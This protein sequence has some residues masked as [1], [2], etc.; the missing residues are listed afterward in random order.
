MTLP[1][2]EQQIGQLFIL[3]FRGGSVAADDPIVEDIRL[4]NLGGVILFDRHLASDKKIN[5]IESP[6]QLINLIDKLQE[7]AE[8]RLLIGIDQEGGMVSR[9]K[10]ES[11]FA[12]TPAAKELGNSKDLKATG[13]SARQTARMLGSLGINL[14]FAPVVDLNLNAKNP[15]IGKYDRSFSSDASKVIEHSKAWIKAHR[16]SNI[17]SCLKHFPGHGSSITDSHLGFVDISDSWSQTEL[18]P[19]RE[20][21]QSGLADTIMVGHLYNRTID[22][23]HPAT[24]SR[25]TLSTLLREELQ[26]DGATISD[27]MQMKAITQRYGIEEACCKAISAGIDLVIIGNNL[28]YDPDV[29]VKIQKAVLRGLENNTVSE[30][31]ITEA[32][33]RIQHLKQHIEGRSNE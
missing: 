33:K 20:L 27:D 32:W 2:I 7:A 25:A 22:A 24:L 14:N 4:R 28:I 31:R 18:L 10:H 23:T 6:Q 13:K 3:G 30:Q 9:L 1:T 15:I 17:L 29:L 26:F 11:G 21:I 12:I 8:T 19:Y 5:N 16:E